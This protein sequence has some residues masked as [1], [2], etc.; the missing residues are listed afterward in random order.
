MLSTKICKTPGERGCEEKA[1]CSPSSQKA[2]HAPEHPSPLPWLQWVN[3]KCPLQVTL[4]GLWMPARKH[5]FPRKRHSPSSCIFS[6]N[7]SP[8]NKSWRGFLHS[9]TPL[10]PSIPLLLWH[11]AAGDST[12]QPRWQGQPS[13]ELIS[14]PSAP[15]TVTH[16]TWNAHFTCGISHW[17]LVSAGTQHLRKSVP[18]TPGC[19]HTCAE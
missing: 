6:T 17:L 9:S 12:R 10:L 11:L 7:L 18:K 19:K 8:R 14:T 3:S 15:H 13:R 16:E 5:S 4:L 1:A 2:A